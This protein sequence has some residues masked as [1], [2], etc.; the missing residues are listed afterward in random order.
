MARATFYTIR[1]ALPGRLDDFEYGTLELVKKGRG[2]RPHVFS[3][4]STRGDMV[5][6]EADG[7]ESSRGQVSIYVRE[8]ARNPA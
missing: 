7:R 8:I 4:K 3:Y 5:I 2:S 6:V 1:A